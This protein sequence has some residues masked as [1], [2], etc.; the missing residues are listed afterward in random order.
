[1]S[2]LPRYTVTVNGK[3][4]EATLCRVGADSIDFEVAGK[5]YHVS[6]GVSFLPTG[7]SE[8]GN[9]RVGATTPTPGPLQVVPLK[10][11]PG[12]AAS[13]GNIRAPMPGI[14]VS[15]L[16]KEGESVTAGQTVAVIE[17]MKMENNIIAPGSGIAQSVHVKP[18]KEVELGHILISLAPTSASATKSPAL[19]GA[20]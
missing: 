3:T 2:S 6:L 19:K 1:M 12:S 11:P 4:V 8:P 13:D 18:G 17:A 7:S 15:V 20:A 16:V 9:L 5:P 14:V 10:P